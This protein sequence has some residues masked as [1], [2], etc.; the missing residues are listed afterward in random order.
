MNQSSNSTPTANSPFSSMY[1]APFGSLAPPSYEN[2]YESSV[3]FDQGG[4]YADDRYGG[5]G[6][7]RSDFGSELYGKRPEDAA[8]RFDSGYDDGYG[9]GVYAYQGGKVEP[10]GARG[11]ASKSSTWSAATP[12][13]DDYG[14]P[15]NIP[16]KKDPPASSLKVVR[17]IPKVEAQE[18][19]KNWV[20]K[21]RVKLLAE[22]GGQSTMDVLC[23]VFH[24]VTGQFCC[25]R[26]CHL[27]NCLV[28]CLVCSGMF[29]LSL[30]DRLFRQTAED[31]CTWNHEGGWFLLKKKKKKKKEKNPH[32]NCPCSS[33]TF[34][35]FFVITLYFLCSNI[36]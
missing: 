26:Y 21:F 7:S 5:Y 31:R 3:K 33:V 24:A 2:P 13:F 22:S 6:R 8:P 30:R 1:S 25:C 4:G 35:S 32:E 27:F 19:V 17:A 34:S 18:D 12:A 29:F 23:Q 28:L 11:T 16:P 10:Y 9:D 14:R 36:V 15:I 20:Q